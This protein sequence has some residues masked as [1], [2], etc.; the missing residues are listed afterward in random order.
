MI[1]SPDLIRIN[2]TS[3]GT[4]TMSKE[5]RPPPQQPKQEQLVSLLLKVRQSYVA[6]PKEQRTRPVV[7]DAKRGGGQNL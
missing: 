7:S 5:I 1:P 4:A 3:I 6:V 2:P